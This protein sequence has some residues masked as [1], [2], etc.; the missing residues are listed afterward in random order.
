L[1]SGNYERARVQQYIAFAANEVA[2]NVGTWLYPIM[3][4]F[5]YDKVAEKA[6]KENLKR[7]LVALDAELMTKTFLVGERVT[8][9]DITLACSL[10]H[11]FT[12][13]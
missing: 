10:F 11:A 3:G 4:Y 12:K 5:P 1:G 9:A 8:L 6:A 7:A 2:R 13:V